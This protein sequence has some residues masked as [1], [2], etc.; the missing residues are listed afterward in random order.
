MRSIGRYGS[1]CMTV[2]GDLLPFSRRDWTTPMVALPLY[3]T[4]QLACNLVEEEV[5]RVT[6][7]P[8]TRIFSCPAAEH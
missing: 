7:P 6:Y 8:T 1:L 2:M 4:F 3:M 5:Q